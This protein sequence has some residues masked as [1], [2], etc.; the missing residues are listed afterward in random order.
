MELGLGIAII[1]WDK[2]EW[3]IGRPGVG[4]TNL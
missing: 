1:D 2:R 3:I 4:Y